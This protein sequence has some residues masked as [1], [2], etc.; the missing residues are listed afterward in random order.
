MI[1]EVG[2]WRIDASRGD[3]APVADDIR[4]AFARLPIPGLRSFHMGPSVEEP[5]RWVVVVVWDTV[6]DH[7]RFVASPEGRPAA[8]P[9]RAVHGRRLGCHALRAHGREGGHAVI[10]TGHLG[11]RGARRSPGARDRRRRREW[12]G[13]PGHPHESRRVRPFG[14]HRRRGGHPCVRR[15]LGSGCHRGLRRGGDGRCADRRRPRGRHR[16]PVGSSPT[17]PSPTGSG[18]ST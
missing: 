3:F 18:S 8:A 5:A 14:R 4:D 11:V 10:D 6:E 17:R 9:A 2:L 1:V 13:D 7:R 16:R 12:L 15:D